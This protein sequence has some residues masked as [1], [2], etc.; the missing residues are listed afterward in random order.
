VSA[1]RSR[2][3]RKP[4]SLARPFGKRS[5]AMP[6]VKVI[7]LVGESS[8]SFED[9]VKNALD[10][11]KK[12]VRDIRGIDVKSFNAVVKSDKI[13]AYRANVKVAFL[14]HRK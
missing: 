12:S 14:V 7:E 13:T 6:V 9:A 1:A 4:S 3:G 5:T 11:A 8:T 10:D 2:Q